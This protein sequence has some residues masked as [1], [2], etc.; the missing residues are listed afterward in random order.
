M[1]L[2]PGKSLF[3]YAPVALLAPAGAPLLWRR[4][5]LETI[6]LIGLVVAHVLLYAHWHAWDGGGVWGPRLLLPIV[7]LL[8][9]LAAPVFERAAAGGS[10]VTRSVTG[11][12]LALGTINAL[13]GVIVNPSIYL[14]TGIPRRLIYF[15][16]AH[17]P[18][19]AHWRIAAERWQARYGDGQCVLGDGF[20]FRKRA[21]RCCRV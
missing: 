15:D 8:A 6:L 19:L 18:L 20:Y 14:N 10:I 21:M 13:A 3:L 9:V 7:P 4:Q 17:S 2:S 12:I 16:A 1:L 5:R 11:A